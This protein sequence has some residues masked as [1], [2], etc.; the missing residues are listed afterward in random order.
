M[1]FIAIGS[2][3]L[4]V[5]VAWI[6]Y[7]TYLSFRNNYTEDMVIQGQEIKHVFDEKVTFIE[8]FLQFIGS[9]IKNSDKG[10][11]EDIA[12]MIKYRRYD[13]KNQYD[14]ND[15][16]ITWNMVDY[17]TPEGYLVADSRF[18]LRRP[19]EVISKRDWIKHSKNHPW[20]LQFSNPGIGFITGDYILPSGI[21]IYDEKTKK[22]HGFLS[23]SIS[24]EKLTSSLIQLVDE[25]IVFAL[26]NDSFSTILISDPFIDRTTLEEKVLDYKDLIL[27]NQ[28]SQT[29][30]ELEKY[31]RIGNVVFSHYVHSS[32]FPFWFLIGFNN[33]YYAK[34]L[35]NE[36]LPRLAINLAFWTVFSSIII[37]L[38]YQV[39]KPI[40][41]LGKAADNIS[42]G[43]SIHLPNFRAK[44][45]SIL[46][47]QLS[48]ISQ[49]HSSLKSKQMK[50]SKMN[51][52]L[53]TA[54]EFIKSNMSFL[55][56]E[57]IN[58][59]SSILE[60]S[61][62]LAKKIESKLD[63]KE[64]LYYLSIIKN[65]SI[66][67]SDQLN[68][69]MKM[70]RFQAEQKQIEEKPI[71]LK[72]LVDWNLSMIMHHA[73]YKKVSIKSNVPEGL[74]LL[75]DEIMIGQLIQNIA[76]NGAKYNKLEGRLLVEAFINKKGE[77]EIHFTDSGVGIGAR[78]L[79]NVFK[80]FK[81]AKM[82]KN[83]KTVGYGIGL[84]YAQKCVQAHG[85]RILVSSKLNQGSKFRVI[86]P[87]SR[88]I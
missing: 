4:V 18:G 27:E 46:A 88:T 61:K 82:I 11:I 21:G 80:V 37:Y 58:P 75:G 14:E 83:S 81:R 43:K 35:W 33:T 47:K 49:I 13:Q 45:L 57:L 7:A 63:D 60:F 87:K 54:N 78:D 36:I 84:A 31:I 79:E 9:Q 29:T 38:L 16:A 65:A 86:F 77:I 85:G 71:A 62:M 39:V 32:R 56:H 66:H 52:D 44:E 5:G 48:M 22:F 10:G 68:F 42:K 40:I 6:A 25:S 3:L 59:T 23:S 12:A 55:S 2:L 64:A 76:A 19:M 15:D 1:L 70:F 50:L 30:V 28:N 73:N 51:T 67:L 20:T 17:I 24:I 34:E 69:F 26:L 72:Q 74:K 53:S 8:H 41:I